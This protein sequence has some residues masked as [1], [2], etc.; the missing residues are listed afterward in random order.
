LSSSGGEVISVDK[1]TMQT[2]IS[3]MPEADQLAS[4]YEDRSGLLWIEPQ[5]P[6]VIKFDPAR[7]TFKR[8]HQRTDAYY[9]HIDKVY[10]VLRTK[11]DWCG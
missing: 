9:N 2:G 1:G 10:K 4:I 3:K 11:A 8:F 6:G 5:K 7:N